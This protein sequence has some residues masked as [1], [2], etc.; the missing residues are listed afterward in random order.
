MPLS[1]VCCGPGYHAGCLRA[2]THRRAV[3]V[4]V[5][6]GPQALTAGFQAVNPGSWIPRSRGGT[7][8]MIGISDVNYMDYDTAY[9]STDYQVARL[10]IYASSTAG[11]VSL[12]IKHHA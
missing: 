7:L 11:R 6:R 5:P 1:C 8:N 2:V 3:P 9:F 10:M 12:G 4:P